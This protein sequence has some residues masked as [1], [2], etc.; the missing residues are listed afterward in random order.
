[1]EISRTVW[2]YRKPGEWDRENQWRRCEMFIS[3]IGT[4]GRGK[5]PSREQYFSAVRHAEKLTSQ[6]EEVH[7]ISG[8]AAWMDHVAVSLYIMGKADSLTLYF[9][10]KWSSFSERFEGSTFTAGVACH[11]HHQFSHVMTGGRSRG[12]T[13]HGITLA[14]EKGAK[15][16]E[17]TEGFKAR[18]LLVGKTDIL[19]C[20]HWGEGVGPP[21]GGSRHTW[22]NS[23]ASEKWYVSIESL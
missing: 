4:A 19:L 16:H 17:I 2:Q 14:I 1:V 9:P 3:I 13:M 15:Y 20:F 18:N 12:R 6:Y 21:P 8:G 10:C 11:Y 7:L 5:Q 23:N 22:D